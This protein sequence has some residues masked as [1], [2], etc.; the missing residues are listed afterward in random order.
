MN[1]TDIV[2]GYDGSAPSRTALR[3]AAVEAHR[4]AAPLR[5]LLA[6]EW[7]WLGGRFT[8]GGEL[9][10]AVTGQLAEMEAE[11]VGEAAVVA[12]GLTITT[13]AV[14]G[15]A[16]RVLVEA[17]ET[18]A[19]V[20]VGN[21]GR[22]GFAS[23]LA[24]SVSQQVATHACCPVVVVRGRADRVDGPVV[25][26]VDGSVSA[27]HALGAAFEE[28]AARNASMLA[29]RVHPSPVHAWGVGVPLA[30]YDDTE[31][32][33]AAG[34]DLDAAVA[35]WQEKYPGVPVQARLV[36]GHPVDV[37]VD[38]SREA[39]LAV[40]GTRGHGGFGGSLLGSVGLALVHH[41]ECPVLIAR[42][43]VEGPR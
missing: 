28:A 43:T 4:R 32:R 19:L 17:S 7:T 39:Q 33:A 29:I 41:G 35:R 14:E 26:G 5:I 25:S 1:R 30:V 16:A 22:G 9:E 34:R 8:A 10:E 20:V 6:Y 21:R 40:V 13:A 42:S 36:D 24:G 27:E 38:A 31:I 12:P 18:A 2:I 15:G 11:A 37:L 23:L 3:W